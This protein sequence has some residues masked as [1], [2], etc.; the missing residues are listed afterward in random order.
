MR[1]IEYKDIN[2]FLNDVEDSLLENETENNLLLGLAR[3]LSKSTRESNGLLL[4]SVKENG[5]VIGAALRTDVE[6]PLSLS[7]MSKEAVSTLAVYLRSSKIEGVVGNIKT[8]GNF[9][10]ASGLK[11]EIKMNQGVYELHELIEPNMPI[12]VSVKVATED[13]LD[14]SIEFVRGFVRECFP[15]DAFRDDE[16]IRQTALRHIEL[17]N[18]VILFY[19]DKA[20]AC[21]SQNRETK[22]SGCVSLVYTIPDFRGKGFGSLVTSEATKLAFSRGK[23]FTNLFT[24]LNNPTSNSIYQKIGYKK[25]AESQHLRFIYD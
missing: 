2:I 18:L 8:V 15:E 5:V 7:P 21:A 17:R 3:G 11:T 4:Y 19:K 24:D 22:N 23:R 16:S 13:D 14:P 12:D 6:R 10:E 9:V 25:I 20:V 1:V